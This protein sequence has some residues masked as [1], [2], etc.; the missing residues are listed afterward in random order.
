M[1]KETAMI[2]YPET[3]MEPN[4]TPFMAL[5]AIVGRGKMAGA[6]K[7]LEWARIV[8]K[9]GWPAVI[10]A[11]DKTE[12]ANRWAATVETA[13]E[14]ARLASAQRKKEALQ[15]IKPPAKATLPSK[16]AA[17]EFAKI[18]ARIMGTP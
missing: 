14:N 8:D 15:R 11:A 12:P 3:M 2:P 13:C 7:W 18:R 16:E 6:D 5:I 1:T 10:A 9:Y 17:A 4:R